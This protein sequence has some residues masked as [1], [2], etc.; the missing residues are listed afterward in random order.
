MVYSN[1]LDKWVYMDPS[2]QAYFKDEKGTLL[3]IEEVREKMIKGDKLILNDDIDHNGNG[4]SK[5]EYIS[6]MSK[7]LFWFSC[8]INSEFNSESGSKKITMYQLI[9]KGYSLTNE[10]I[11]EQNGVKIIYISNPD[12]F[13]AKP[14]DI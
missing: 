11:V 2:F 12:F 5:K 4:Y 1:S 3:S 8:L 7:N 13:W 9:P 14:K 10:K 6:Y